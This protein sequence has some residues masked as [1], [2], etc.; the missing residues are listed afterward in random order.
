MIVNC[1]RR[2]FNCKIGDYILDNGACYQIIT[3][4][5]RERYADLTPILAKTIFKK[6][7]KDGYIKLSKKK[8]RSMSSSVDMDL[9]EFTEKSEEY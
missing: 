6:L 4:S 8:Y 9:Y 3:K 1:R 5:Y 2:K 7:L